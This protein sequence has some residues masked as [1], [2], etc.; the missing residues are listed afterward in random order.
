[1]DKRSGIWAVLHREDTPGDLLTENSGA[2]SVGTFDKVVHQGLCKGTEQ[3]QEQW[4]SFCM[5]KQR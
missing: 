2:W 5:T 1:M 4:V 3:Q